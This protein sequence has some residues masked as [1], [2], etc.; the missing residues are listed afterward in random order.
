MNGNC[1]L[2]QGKRDFRDFDFD[3]PQNNFVA[4]V[5]EYAGWGYFDP[6]ES[7]YREGYQCPPVNW[8]LN[9]ERKQAFFAKLK[10]IAGDDTKD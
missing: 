3:K 4:A 1:R 6:G 5:G 8:G 9:T 10:V 7:N 2:N